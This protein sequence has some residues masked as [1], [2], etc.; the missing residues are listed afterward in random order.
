MHWYCIHKC[1][2]IQPRG[3]SKSMKPLHSHLFIW[4]KFY[5][6]WLICQEIKELVDKNCNTENCSYQLFVLRS[7]RIINFSLFFICTN[8]CIFT[9][10]LQSMLENC[11]NKRYDPYTW[12]FLQSQSEA[13]DKGGAKNNGLEYLPNLIMFNYV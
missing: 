11:C 4:S 3:R 7:A 8:C 5:Y 10:L 13:A 12:Q 1:K 2:R 9:K 6:L